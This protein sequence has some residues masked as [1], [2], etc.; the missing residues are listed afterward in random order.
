MV[1]ILCKI[2]ELCNFEI[3]STYTF[4][5]CQVYFTS[6][7]V[8]AQWHI[9]QR[10]SLCSVGLYWLRKTDMLISINKKKMSAFLEQQPFLTTHLFVCTTRQ[11]G[12]VIF[13]SP[14][15][16][17]GGTFIKSCKL[18]PWPKKKDITYWLQEFWWSRNCIQFERRPMQ[19]SDCCGQIKHSDSQTLN[20]YYIR[21][22]SIYLDGVPTSPYITWLEP[23]SLQSLD[24]LVICPNWELSSVG[25]MGYVD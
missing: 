21:E 3:Y 8:S 19:W 15:T 6:C 23:K 9:V 7:Q 4:A 5:Y 22:S 13:V 25:I 17:H 24:N 1:Y 11:I 18:F 20:Q 16:R 10:A 14:E 12:K 2:N